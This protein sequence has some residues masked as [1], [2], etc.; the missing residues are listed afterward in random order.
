M[1]AIEGGVLEIINTGYDRGFWILQND[2][3]GVELN[4]EETKIDEPG[5]DAE[6]IDNIRG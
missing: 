4:D 2:N 5:C 3:Q 6:C 1:K